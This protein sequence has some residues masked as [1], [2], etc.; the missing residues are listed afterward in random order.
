MLAKAS[1]RLRTRAPNIR[2]Q[3]TRSSASPPHSPLTRHPLGGLWRKLLLAMVALGLPRCAH[4]RGAT[5][6]I[7][8]H[9]VML[10]TY[11]EAA[12][13]ARM[14]GVV[15][16]DASVDGRGTVAALDILKSV[17]PLLDTTAREAVQQ[18]RF[19]PHAGRLQV[20]V[21]FYLDDWGGEGCTPGPAWLAPGMV[22]VYGY[23]RIVDRSGSPL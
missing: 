12:R 9:Q 4:S 20:T 5:E 6:S 18:W 21:R 16:L 7:V 10:P 13:R 15:E 23:V 17:C 19:S 14:E 8:P 3:R 1:D 11:P 2:V 22:M